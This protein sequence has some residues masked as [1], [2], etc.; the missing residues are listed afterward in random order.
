MYVPSTLKKIKTKIS[1]YVMDGWKHKQQ[2]AL[3]TLALD[4][5]SIQ[6]ISYKL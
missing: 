6:V 4:P 3:H 1:N 2:S 5:S